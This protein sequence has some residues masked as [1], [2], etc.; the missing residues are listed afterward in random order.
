MKTKHR[1]CLFFAAGLLLI[2]NAA[3]CGG[4]GGTTAALSMDSGYVSGQSADMG[5]NQLD[6]GSSDL[7]PEDRGDEASGDDT[8]EG[9]NTDAPEAFRI[10][11]LP[12]TQH[13]TVD[14]P[15]IFYSQMRWIRENHESLD[16]EFVLHVGDITHY[17][18]LTGWENASAGYELIDGAV[19]HAIAVGNHDM[20]FPGTM[21][22]TYFNSYFPV[23]RY[24]SFDHFGGSYP[25]GKMDNS[26]HLFSAGGIDWLVVSIRYQPS[27]DIIE[28]AGG[29]VE[30]FPNRTV[31]V[32]THAFVGP[33]GEIGRDATY[34]WNSFIRSHENI[35][36]VFNGHYT[37]A[38][39]GRIETAGDAGNTIYG[40]F[41]N[42]QKSF[43]GGQGYLRIIT[44]DPDTA[45]LSVETYS[46][47]LDLYKTDP[48]NN[49]T[50]ENYSARTGVD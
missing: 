28:W 21:D 1:I 5:G 26:Y 17:N 25:E 9:E 33:D 38:F 29:V 32:V 20:E 15:D 10:V 16:I 4:G 27:S 22:T 18:D 8:D 23:S 37:D 14:F 42:Y 24:S 45:S 43:Q 44:I 39:S 13:L 34:L 12:D 30:A 50:I 11:V 19:P 2:M 40:L 49:L 6:D 7:S 35:S 46:P 36:L 41:A 47:W 31:I 3:S 48:G